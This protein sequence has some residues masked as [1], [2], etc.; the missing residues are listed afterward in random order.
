MTRRLEWPLRL[1]AVLLAPSIAGCA[2][3]AWA[4]SRR[5]AADGGRAAAD[6]HVERGNA[7]DA[8]PRGSMFGDTIG[9][10]FGAGGL[11]PTG[12]GR[13][14]GSSSIGLGSIGSMGRGAGTGTGQGFGVG[15]GRMSDSRAPRLTVRVETSASREPGLPRDVVQRV[16]L[17]NRAMLTYCVESNGGLPDGGALDVSVRFV[18]DRSGN[19]ST[20]GLTVG[21][22][23]GPVAACL[24]HRYALMLFTTPADGAPVP[25]TQTLTFQMQPTE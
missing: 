7:R 22:V 12:A 21:G 8:G 14:G 13:G 10:S 18:I 1:A 17:R 20:E 9:D 15:A 16:V 6:A 4:Q 25:T 24:S 23:T 11:G 2:E 3:N 5:A 19:V